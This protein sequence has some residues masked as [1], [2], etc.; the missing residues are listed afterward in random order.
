MAPWEPLTLART[1]NFRFIGAHQLA[2]TRY[3]RIS[4]QIPPAAKVAQIIDNADQYRPVAN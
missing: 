2:D 1:P 4:N 3:P